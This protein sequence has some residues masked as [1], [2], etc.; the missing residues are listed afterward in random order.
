MVEEL[1]RRLAEE[2]GEEEDEEEDVE[3]EGGRVG[4]VKLPPIDAAGQS[5]R[6]GSAPKDESDIRDLEAD[7]EVDEDDDDVDGDGEEE[8]DDGEGHVSGGGEAAFAA[9][10]ASDTTMEGVIGVGG[11]LM[12]QPEFE[13]MWESKADNKLA[14]R[15]KAA[16]AEGTAVASQFAKSKMDVDILNK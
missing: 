1:K 16:V 8:A 15:L 10:A 14:N 13:G 7:E 4:K 3:K 5:R 6:R 2:E 11:D 12:A 9:A